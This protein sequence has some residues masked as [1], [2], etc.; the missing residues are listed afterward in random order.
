M[1]ET[2]SKR[3]C[4]LLAIFGEEDA[5]LL[6]R[7]VTLDT[8]ADGVADVERWAKHRALQAYDQSSVRPRFFVVGHW[9]YRT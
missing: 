7:K 8:T 3:T 9:S 1:K 5:R 6:T 4:D 2:K